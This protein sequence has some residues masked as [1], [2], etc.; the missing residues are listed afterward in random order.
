MYSD[1]NFTSA[2]YV[3]LAS[4]CALVEIFLIFFGREQ[5]PLVVGVKDACA[6]FF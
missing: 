2:I 1:F 6:Y 5:L 3:T 4:N